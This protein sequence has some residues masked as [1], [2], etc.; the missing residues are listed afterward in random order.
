[1]WDPKKKGGPSNFPPRKG[2]ITLKAERGAGSYIVS[3]HNR[4]AGAGRTGKAE[5]ENKNTRR[6]YKRDSFEL[7]NLHQGK[8][9][10]WGETT[11]KRK[12]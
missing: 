1:L 12:C 9:A 7:K 11:T 2:G 10:E 6:D 4:P 8:E 5:G 3:S